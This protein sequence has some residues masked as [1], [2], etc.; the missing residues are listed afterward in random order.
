MLLSVYSGSSKEKG[1]LR[2]CARN[3]GLEGMEETEVA[4]R[5]HRQYQFGPSKPLV[6]EGGGEDHLNPSRA[7]LK[8]LQYMATVTNTSYER[9]VAAFKEGRELTDIFGE[10]KPTIGIDSEVHS[11]RRPSITP[12]PAAPNQVQVP[13]HRRD[14]GVGGT[15]R[16]PGCHIKEAPRGTLVII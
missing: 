1:W 2:I 4:V 10:P 5:R 9:A 8:M 7:V 15:A 12:T 16:L 13:P 11:L 6:V 14:R 3:R